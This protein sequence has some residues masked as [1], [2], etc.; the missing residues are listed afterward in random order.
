MT[1]H[2]QGDSGR[3][4]S[5]SENPDG[6]LPHDGGEMPTNGLAYVE[7]RN[8]KGWQMSAPAWLVKW[9]GVVEYRIHQPSPS[10]ESAS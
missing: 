5:M 10:K 9:A 6:W 8:G 7:V 4:D 3:G 1:R 2:I